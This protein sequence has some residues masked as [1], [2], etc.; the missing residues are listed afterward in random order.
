MILENEKFTIHLIRDIYKNIKDEF[1]KV[2]NLSIDMKNISEID[3]SGLQLLVSLKKS[4]DKE[5]KGFQLINISD[6]LLYSFEL[7]GIDSI[8]EI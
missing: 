7:S 2:D 8:L 3:L 1:D 4:C 5:N 6:E